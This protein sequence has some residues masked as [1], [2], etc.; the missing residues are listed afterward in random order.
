MNLNGSRAQAEAWDGQFEF[1]LCPTAQV[2]SAHFWE[3]LV[4]IV[5]MLRKL[6]WVG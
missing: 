1:M 6:N 5:L 3:L 2:S 4:A